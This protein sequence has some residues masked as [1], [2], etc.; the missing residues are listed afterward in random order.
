[1]MYISNNELTKTDKMIKVTK[2][3]S[4]NKNVIAVMQYMII[5]VE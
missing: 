2:I 3:A 1:M 4:T 5:R